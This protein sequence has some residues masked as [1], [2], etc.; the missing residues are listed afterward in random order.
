MAYSI[1]YEYDPV[2][3]RT[4]MTDNLTAEVTT[5]TYDAANQLLTEEDSLGTTN[6]T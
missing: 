1:S 6:Y 3:N 4:K 5:Y 2:G